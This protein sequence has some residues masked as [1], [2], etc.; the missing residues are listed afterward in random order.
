MSNDL[1]TKLELIDKNAPFYHH[2]GRFMI[3]FAAL[4]GELHTIFQRNAG[5]DEKVARTII[6][7]MSVGALSSLVNQ[8]IHAS[9]K[10]DSSKKSEV[11]FIID[12]VNKI[13][14][15][16]HLL[17]HR[18]V[19]NIHDIRGEIKSS[20]EVIAKSIEQTEILTLNLEDIKAAVS[21]LERIIERFWYL[22]IV[23]PHGHMGSMA[24]HHRML[25]HKR[26]WLYKPRA[27]ENPY[28]RPSKGS[29]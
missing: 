13:S 2:F 3:I 6:G 12:Q 26:A 10:F 24:A 16:R 17:V 14:E 23:T 22:L 4:E 5:L 29:Q 28:R 11:Q 21:D 20:N 18:G 25:D 8:V 15:F 27:R 9:N 1:D 7:G 19:Q